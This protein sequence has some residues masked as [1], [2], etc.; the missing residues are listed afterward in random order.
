MGTG[1]GLGTGGRKGFSVM[2]G[3]G[4]GTGLSKGLYLPLLGAAPPAL[5]AKTE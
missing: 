4:L 5:G 1:K 2:Y 3:K